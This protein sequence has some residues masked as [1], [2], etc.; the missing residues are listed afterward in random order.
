MQV[1]N[2]YCWV[3]YNGN[4]PGN[5]FLDYAEWIKRSAERYDVETEIIPN[6]QLLMVVENGKSVIKVKSRKENPDFIVFAD[7]DIPLARHLEQA[8]YKVFNSSDSI[9][10]CDNKIYMYQKLVD[11]GLP[12]PKTIFA[13]KLFEGTKYN[14]LTI[15]D[16]VIEELGL[17]LIIKEAYG[18]FGQQV[19][20][21]HNKEE[22]LQKI[23]ELG[24]TPF[25]F[26]EFIS[27]SYG[28]DI[29]I[30]VVGNRVITSMLRVSKDDFR[31]NVSAGG[32]IEPYD[33]TE[34]E[35]ELAIK[36]SNLVGTTFAGVD[37]LFGENNKPIICEINS[38]A[39]IRNI[40]HCTGVDISESIINHI[41]TEVMVDKG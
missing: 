37:I 18:S 9:E 30:N 6:H 23:C 1:K 14:D 11:K 17:P 41:L 19:Y 10:I 7:K 39:H 38:N 12:I 24:S 36:A 34:K 3:I 16:Q 5:K 20:L 4:L 31:A 13:P 26:Q 27:T 2:K 40:Y 29:R 28:K 8:G 32:S 21:L 22:L 35:K 25:L 33:P 15:L